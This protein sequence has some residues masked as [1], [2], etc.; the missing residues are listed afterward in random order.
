MLHRIWK[1]LLAVSSL[2]VQLRKLKPRSMASLVKTIIEQ[3]V[4]AI[5]GVDVDPDRVELRSLFVKILNFSTSNENLKK[6]FTEKIKEGRIQ[7]AK[8]KKHLKNGKNVSMGFGS[9]ELDSVETAGKVCKDLHGTILDGHA[10][11]LQHCNA[12]THVQPM[13]PA[14]SSGVS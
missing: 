6:H 5:S 1:W 4:E 13:M 11:S 8:V 7:S 10:F 3:G 2:Q 14:V 12:I 9:I